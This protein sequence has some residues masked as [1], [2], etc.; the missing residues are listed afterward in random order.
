MLFVKIR[1]LCSPAGELPNGEYNNTSSNSIP[2]K[3]RSQC[4]TS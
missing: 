2:T 4:R 3:I 1:Q